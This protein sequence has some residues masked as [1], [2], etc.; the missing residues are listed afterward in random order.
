MTVW[1]LWR[2]GELLTEDDDILVF[3]SEE[4]A[5]IY[6]RGNGWTIGTISS[7]CSLEELKVR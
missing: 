5:M 7:Y 2:F 4:S 1:V 3:S 6:C